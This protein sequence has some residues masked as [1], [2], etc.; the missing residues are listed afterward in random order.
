MQFWLDTEK[1]R[2]AAKQG[3]EQWALFYR[4]VE[5]KYFKSRN[6]KLP[7]AAQMSPL[8]LY[9]KFH[10]MFHVARSTDDQKGVIFSS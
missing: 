4:K 8:Q 2:R 9:R 1:F 3:E 10:G 5:T 6:V 7:P